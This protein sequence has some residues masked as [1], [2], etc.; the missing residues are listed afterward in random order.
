MAFSG[1][2]CFAD[3]PFLAG[4][5]LLAALA[6]MAPFLPTEGAALRAAVFAA[7]L[8]FAQRAFWAAAIFSRAPALIVRFAGLFPRKLT[9]GGFFEADAAA[10]LRAAFFAALLDLAQRAFCA[11]EILARAAAL[12]VRRG[13][14]LPTLAL[15]AFFGF[16]FTVLLVPAKSARACC[17]REI[18][19]SISKMMLLVSIIPRN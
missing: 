11:A 19:A 15:A 12:K 4:A 9:P 10:G 16:V 18:S 6:G 14:T 8:T 7:F 13:L 3:L 5:D 17:N 1:P 2:D